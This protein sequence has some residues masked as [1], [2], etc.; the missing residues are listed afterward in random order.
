MDPKECPADRALK[1]HPELREVLVK[2]D[3]QD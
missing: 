1:A 3:Q 2:M